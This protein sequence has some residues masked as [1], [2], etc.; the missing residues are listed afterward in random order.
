MKQLD[1]KTF[2]LSSRVV[3]EEEKSSLT[4]VVNRKSRIIMKD[5]RRLLDQ[6]RQI[7]KTSNKTVLIFTTAPVCSKTKSFLNSNGVE[8][9]QENYKDKMLKKDENQRTLNIKKT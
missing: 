3:I 8:I 5:G 9:T 2:N 6:I 4:L 7:K 1:P